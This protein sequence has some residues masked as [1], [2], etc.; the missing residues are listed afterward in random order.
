MIRDRPLFKAM[1]NQKG[2][3]FV[4]IIIAV[5]VVAAAVFG[6]YLYLSPRPQSESPAPSAEV[7][8]SSKYDLVKDKYNLSDEQVEILKK[9]NQQDKSL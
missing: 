1:I 3:S 8:L 6:A 2:F 4:I 7:D 5:T 9:V